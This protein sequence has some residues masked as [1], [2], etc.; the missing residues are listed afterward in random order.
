[1]Y[2]K[3]GNS[4]KKEVEMTNFISLTEDQFDAIYTITPNEHEDRYETYGE[5]YEALK[6]I[7]EKSPRKVWT[8]VDGEDGE[9]IFV[10]GLHFV[11]RIYYFVT[12]QEVPED[13][14]VEVIIDF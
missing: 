5:E 8:A 7:Y 14:D 2:K 4:H 3:R 9:L 6:V 10:S 1:M 11:N 13:T 12:D